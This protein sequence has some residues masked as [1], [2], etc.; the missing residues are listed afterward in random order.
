MSISD[1]SSDVCSSD[2][3]VMRFRRA[4]IEQGKG[5]G[6]SPLAGGIGLYGL[7]ADG[8]AGAEIYS[9]GATKDQAAILFRDAIKMRDQSPEIKSRT[10]T[11]GGEGKEHNIAYHRKK[12]FFRRSEERRVGKE[13]VWT[14]RSRGSP[15]H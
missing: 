15:Y 6:K 1:W 13:G 9:A 14:C 5:N 4:Y 10:V 3:E 12:S 7:M 8:E 11:S 2:L